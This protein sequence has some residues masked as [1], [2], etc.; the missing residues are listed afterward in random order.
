MS[1]YPDFDHT[2][3]AVRDIM[4]WAHLLRRTLGATPVEGDA[5]S[6]FRFLQLYVGTADAGGRIELIAPASDGFVT[7][8]L[9]RHGEGPHHITFIVPDLRSAVRDVR[10]LG[11]VV[12]GENYDDSAWYEA[13]IAP[14]AVHG[15]VIQLGQLESDY[16]SP[17]EL[18]AAA[19]RETEVLR[20]SAGVTATTSWA[21]VWDVPVESTA[22]LGPTHLSTTDI[23]F[24]RKLFEGVLGAKTVEHDDGLEFHWPSGIVRTHERST[25]GVTGIDITGGPASGLAIGSAQ[26]HDRSLKE[27]RA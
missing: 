1:R 13:F 2:S 21:S 18:L 24:S 22:V 25:A 4:A 7:R 12:T 16:P 26:L 20:S 27:H 6:E 15:V 17:A 10:A 23:T 3:F 5:L 8:Y 9:D 19:E 11:A 14:S